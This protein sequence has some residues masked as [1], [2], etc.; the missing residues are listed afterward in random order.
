MDDLQGLLSELK[1]VWGRVY[2]A[3]SP[4]VAAWQ[5]YL[6]NS[7]L[8]VISEAI[9][10]IDVL[11]N[12]LKIPA[13]FNPGF[14]LAKS[15]ASL[16]LIQL[17]SVSKNLEAGQ[18]THF[19]N[20]STYITNVISAIN[21][22]VTY[23]DKNESKKIAADVTTELA[24]SLAL[25]STAQEELSKKL[26][27][28]KATNESVAAIEESH[29]KILELH[30]SSE[31]SSKELSA[32]L[33]SSEAKNLE[34]NSILE[35]CKLNQT[36]IDELLKS[37]RELEE[38]LTS[39]KADLNTLQSDSVKQNE[40]INS[41]LPKAASA[42]LAT[43]F[44]TRAGQLNFTKYVW[45]VLFFGSLCSLTFFAWNILH[46]PSIQASDFTTYVLSRLPLTAPLIWL[47]WFSAI[48][49]GNTIRVQEDYAFK[50][51][52]S[53]AFQGYRDHMEH[54]AKIST[55][56]SDSALKLLSTKT[57][58]I[59]SHEPLRIYGTADN[60]ASPSSKLAN[61]FSRSQKPND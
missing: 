21:N 25:L 2:A 39:L 24:Q 50:E 26:E 37:S 52:T 56:D 60:D 43:A 54:M 23:S 18:Y 28:I 35:A 58:E 3:A 14:H 17:I 30:E 4:N 11:I 22:M 5:P 45:L 47:G 20:F 7:S 55:D 27:L 1:D 48:Q 59:L 46:S 33:T 10:S 36:E 31:A 53:K 34:T 13:G 44:S 41:I 57:I 19:T 49:Y 12:K 51:V 61:L 42:G 29:Q 32:L 6:P 9:D 8:E 15:T 40:V 38:T 16:N